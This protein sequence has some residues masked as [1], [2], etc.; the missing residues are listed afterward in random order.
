MARRRKSATIFSHIVNGSKRA[1][2]LPTRVALYGDRA[3]LRPWRRN[4]SLRWRTI[5]ETDLIAFRLR[6]LA[7]FGCVVLIGYG[8]LF[9]FTGWR[10]PV[11]LPWPLN[12]DAGLRISKTDILT[13]VLLYMPLGGLLAVG[14]SRRL[15]ALIWVTLVA[16]CFSLGLETLQIFLPGRVPSVLDTSLNT[17]GAFVG[18]GV[19]LALRGRVGAAGHNWWSA[20]V[21]ADRVS[22]VGWAALA[23]WFCAQLIPF[24]PSIDV[25]SLRHGLKPL[26]YA[27]AGRAAIDPYRTLV[28]V[29]AVAGLMPVAVML[30]RVRYRAAALAAL[31]FLAILPLKVLVVWRQLSPEAL[32][33]TFG[34][35]ALAWVSGSTAP[36]HRVRL[37]AALIVLSVIAEALHPGVGAVTHA[38]NWV[39]FREQLTN[40]VSGLEN[41]VDTMWPFLALVFLRARADAAFR[42]VM[43]A[44]IVAVGLMALEWAQHWIPGRYPDVTDAL[45]GAATW[46]FAALYAASGARLV[47]RSRVRGGG[48]VAEPR[49]GQR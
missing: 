4:D 47:Q 32:L 29:T 18:A 40:P 42:P 41:L 8:T 5:I 14:R 16:G 6:R 28:Y 43:G 21:Y 34:G 2:A 13:N 17:L 15:V 48:G 33:G 35:L 44:A 25:S 27:L 22:Q 36:P 45:V 37:A 1:G 7:I 39:P 46:W 49:S 23:A 30:L 11:H 24:V 12:L 9:P 3:I 20:W 38:F 10:V 26:W 19:V 31:G